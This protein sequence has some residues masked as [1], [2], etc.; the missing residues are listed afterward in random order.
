MSSVQLGGSGNGTFSWSGPNNYTSTQQN[1]TVSVAGT[2]VLTVTG[3]NG[4]TSMAQ[5]AVELDGTLPG[6]QAIGGTL[7]CNVSSVQLGGSGNG[8]FSWS[9]PNNYTSNVQNPTVSVAGTYVLTVTGANGCT[10]TAQ[11]VVEQDNTPPG[12]QATG[13]VV[14]CTVLS[15]QL[16]GSGNGTFSWSGPNNYTSTVQNPT[17]SV[18]GTYVLT[19]TGANGCTS[20]AQAV[21]EQD[22]TLPGAQATGGTLNCTVLSVQL[23]G[24]GNGTFSWSGPNNYTSNVQNPTVSV[25]GTYVLT[26]TGANGC[27]STAQAVVEQDNTPP[28]AQATGGVVNCTVLSLQLGGSGNGTF[29]WSGPNN[30]EQPAEP[31]CK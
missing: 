23:G 11:A 9:G 29:S 12:A 8:T 6:A 31:D 19:V 16:G 7:N 2:Y 1:P 13:G 24:S 22:N 26:V 14:N 30:Y 27:T 17:V 21:V 20:T 25:A 3:A 18:A 4:C 10:S 15:V 28:G 5:A